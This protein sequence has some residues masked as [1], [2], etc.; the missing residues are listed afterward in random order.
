MIAT[1]AAATSSRLMRIPPSKTLSSTMTG[2]RAMP[3]S[4]E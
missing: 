2:S 4:I 1:T 3:S